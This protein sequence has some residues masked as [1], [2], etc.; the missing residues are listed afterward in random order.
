MERITK[1]VITT[2][3]N[4]NRL[5]PFSKEIP[6][7]MLPCYSLSKRGHLVLKPILQLIFESLYD[8]GCREFCFVVGRDRHYIERHFHAKSSSQCNTNEELSALHDKVHSSNIEYVQQS[9]PRGFGDAILKAKTFVGDDN[10]L[11][12]AGDDMVFSQDSAHIKRLED[13]FFSHNADV[14]LLIQNVKRP[15]QYGVIDGVDNGRGVY[16][17]KNIEE[18]P[19][20]PKTN[21]AV[22][23]TYIFK[24][25][26]FSNIETTGQNRYGEIGI[27]D[28]INLC[29]N[30]GRCVGIKLGAKE[31]RMDVGTPENF[32]ESIIKSYNNATHQQ[33]MQCNMSPPPH[34]GTKS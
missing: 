1:A 8:Y 21:L 22:I 12:N 14:S 30:R 19:T 5:L 31:Q 34:F 23:A 28:A 18:K 2:A 24:P 20:M 17:I 7:E 27:E 13:A 11:V 4:G 33:H 15:E 26:I 9:S 25:S 6:K 32:A 3:G 16:A 10:F 29:A